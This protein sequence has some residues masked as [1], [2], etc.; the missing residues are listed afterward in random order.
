MVEGQVEAV[1]PDR[2]PVPGPIT[3]FPDIRPVVTEAVRAA[4][5]KLVEL[6]EKTRGLVWMDGRRAA[7]LGR[8]LEENPQ[9]GWVQLP[10]SGLNAFAEVLEPYIG[11]EGPLWTSARGAYS[12]P[13]AEHA[14]ALTLAVLRVLQF[15][16]RATGWM[17]TAAEKAARPREHSLYRANVL[18]LGAGGIARE[19]IALTA[20]FA[21]RVTVVRRSA[22]PVP[23]AA[24]TVTGERLQEVLPDA[25]VVVVAAALT[26]GT[27]SM[28]GREELA[29]MKPSAV[30]VNIAR[31]GLIDTDALV[32]ALASGA[33][34]G[35]GLDVTDPEPLPDGHPLWSEPRALITPHMASP[36]VMSIP[37]LA[38]QVGLNVEAFLGHG[39]FVGVVDLASE[40]GGVPPAEELPDLDSNQEPAG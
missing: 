4:G 33:I 3:V 20:P 39:R 30:L 25:D 12:E 19:F 27:V 24:R 16:A 14:L 7:E 31:G 34:A 8:A 2:R 17:S 15:R 1:P 23:G 6:S 38:Q 21:P 36:A 18:L 10:S 28:I 26:G 37:L 32:D 29:A 13:V 35:A 22:E 5:G 11:R 40:L 9:I